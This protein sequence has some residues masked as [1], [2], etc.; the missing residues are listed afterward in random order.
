MKIEII[1]VKQQPCILFVSILKYLK[2]YK[3]SLA[4]ISKKFQRII[5]DLCNFY[6]VMNKL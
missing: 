3:T 1:V 2:D 5:N 6:I 4:K